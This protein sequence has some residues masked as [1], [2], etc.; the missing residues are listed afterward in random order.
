MSVSIKHFL[1]LL[2]ELDQHNIPSNCEE[3]LHT[4]IE[5]ELSSDENPS[6]TTLHLDSLLCHES[7]SQSGKVITIFFLLIACLMP[8]P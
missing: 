7:L 4:T 8:H 1:K 3:S 5:C 6:E 2:D